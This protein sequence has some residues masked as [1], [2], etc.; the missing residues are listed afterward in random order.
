MDG[1]HRRPLDE[2][3]GRGADHTCLQARQRHQR[4]AQPE[5]LRRRRRQSRSANSVRDAITDYSNPASGSFYFAPSEETLDA[6]TG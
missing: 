2:D 5:E 1:Q 3:Y 6:I 4:E